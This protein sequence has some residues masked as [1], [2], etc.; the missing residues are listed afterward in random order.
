MKKMKIIVNDLE[1]EVSTSINVK[2][3]INQL[4]MQAEK[5]A[6]EINKIIVPRSTYNEHMVLE[7]DTIEIIKAVGGG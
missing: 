5:I 4:D 2:E 7:N 1:M 3:L 6:I